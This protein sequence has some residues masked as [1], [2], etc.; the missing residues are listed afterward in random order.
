MDVWMNEWINEWLTDWINEWMNGWMVDGWMGGWM[1]GWMDGWI[2]GWM[3]GW[4]NGWMNNER[5]ASFAVINDWI[6]LFYPW[7]FLILYLYVMPSPKLDSK[8]NAFRSSQRG[9]NTDTLP[10]LEY[11][12]CE[13]K[14]VWLGILYAYKGLLLLFGVFLAWE[15]RHVNIPALNDAHYIGM[16]VYNVFIIGVIGVPIAMVIQQAQDAAFALSAALLIFCTTV[17]LCLVF[18]PKV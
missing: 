2:D 9:E 1:D 10:Q 11:C 7:R 14:P 18:I 16:S 12:Y 17:T 6:K 8:L 15:T 13:Y 4:M 5:T 3:D